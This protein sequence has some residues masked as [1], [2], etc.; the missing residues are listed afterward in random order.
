MGFWETVGAQ[1]LAGATVAIVAAILAILV[2]GQYAAARARAQA[3]RELDLAAAA[4]LYHILGKFSA[5]QRTW[6]FHSRNT[7]QVSDERLS[8][9]IWEAAAVE[10]DYEVFTIRVVLEH[11]LSEDQKAALWCL[12]FPL[13][14]LRYTIRNRRPMTWWS[15]DIHPR[16][17]GY[18]KHVA[19]QGLVVF[20][21]RSLTEPSRGSTQRGKVDPEAVLR[22][23]N[24]DGKE[25]THAPRFA[26]LMAKEQQ[27]SVDEW[28]LLAE[29][30]LPALT[31]SDGHLDKRVLRFVAGRSQ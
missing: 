5:V 4:E 13:K 15:S 31:T 2:T 1:A 7:D 26:E 29:Q 17:S 11:D 19:F 10:S 24:G 16:D 12:R 14:E 28:V 3:R 20:F 9:L 8:E 25:F 22:Q 30:L 27:P 6:N 23:V 18:R 21:A